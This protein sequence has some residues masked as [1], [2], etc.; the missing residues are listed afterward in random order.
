MYTHI[1]S[2]HLQVEEQCEID[3]A[4]WPQRQFILIPT[5]RCLHGVAKMTDIC[6]LTTYYSRCCRHLS[7]CKV[8]RKLSVPLIHSRGSKLWPLRLR[9]PAVAKGQEQIEPWPA[10]RLSEWPMR[11]IKP[12]GRA[13]RGLCS[14][15]GRSDDT[16][17]CFGGSRK[18]RDRVDSW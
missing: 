1:E 17:W 2:A 6:F 4:S 15:L 14:Y 9:R 5:N 3:R 7:R 16:D 12:I 11:L 13:Q 18:C 8:H 10:V